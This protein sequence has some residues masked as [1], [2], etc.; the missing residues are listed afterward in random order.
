MRRSI[1]LLQPRYFAD[2]RCIGS[3]CEDTCCAGMGVVIDKETYGKYQE[4]SH[5]DLKPII[6][7]GIAVN[8]ESTSDATYAQVVVKDGHCPFLTDERLCAIQQILGERALSRTCAMFPRAMSTVNGVVERSLYLSCPEAA[9]VVL[10]NP[11]PMQFDQITEDQDERFTDFPILNSDDFADAPK[12]Y[13]YFWEVRAFIV[14]LLQNR[15]YRVWERLI[16]LGL[17]CDQLNQHII[18]QTTDGVPDLMQSY[19]DL[20]ALRGFDETLAGVGVHPAVQLNFLAQSMEHRI[21]SDSVSTRFVD[22]Y[23]ECMEGIGYTPDTSIDDGA[24]RYAAAYEQYY[25]PFM[26]QREHIFENYLVNYVFK[27]LFPFGPQKS[28]YYEEKSVYSEFV[29][30]AAHFAMLRSLLVGMSGYYQS[31]FGEPQIVKLFQS[32]AKAIEHNPPYLKRILKSLEEN[33]MSDM[34]VMAV[35]IKN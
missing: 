33:E 7:T 13:R 23:Y 16:V 8:P 11:E 25:K 35:F 28:V 6:D 20:L 2:F 29:L 27:L 14:S 24:A 34:A 4:C 10:L 18:D 22:C 30:M 19:T 1:K 26:D 17:F 3:D 32:F 5:P 12:P 9:R 15:E 31:S 21:F